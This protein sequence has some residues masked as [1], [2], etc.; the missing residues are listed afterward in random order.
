M[1][2]F[3]KSES[4]FL[5]RILDDGRIEPSLLTT[6]RD[7]AERITSQ[8]LLEWKALNVRQHKAKT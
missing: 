1:L 5:D 7:L 3:T 4:A 6:D 2:P 8:P